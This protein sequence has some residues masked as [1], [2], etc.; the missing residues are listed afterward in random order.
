MSATGPLMLD[1][2]TSV[3]AAGWSGQCQE[4]TSPLFRAHWQ[5][6]CWLRTWHRVETL[7]AGSAFGRGLSLRPPQFEL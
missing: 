7:V 1:E 6:V 3:S 5:P 4:E 2:Q